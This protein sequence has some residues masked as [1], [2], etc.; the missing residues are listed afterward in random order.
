MDYF[1]L[2]VIKAAKFCGYPDLAAHLFE[3]LKG[4]PLPEDEWQEPYENFV[5]AMAEPEQEESVMR[6]K[7]L[8]SLILRS[9]M[10]VQSIAIVR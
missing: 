9:G 4:N 6:A 1:Q 2:A 3:L 10:T 5:E 8:Q 7:N